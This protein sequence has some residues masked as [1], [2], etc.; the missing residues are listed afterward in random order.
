MENDP[1]NKDNPPSNGY[2]IR[3]GYYCGEDDWNEWHIGFSLDAVKK[4]LEE[5]AEP[6]KEVQGFPFLVRFSLNYFI[7]VIVVFLRKLIL[8]KARFT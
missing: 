4:A 8:Q 6:I 3:H 7:V 5:V 2:D 1:S